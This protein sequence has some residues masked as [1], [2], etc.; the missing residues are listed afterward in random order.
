MLRPAVHRT[1]T[2]TQ[3]MAIIHFCGLFVLFFLVCCSAPRNDITIHKRERHTPT[4]IIHIAHSTQLMS[5][6]IRLCAVFSR[7]L[8]FYEHLFCARL[9]YYGG[10]L[11]LTFASPAEYKFDFFPFHLFCTIQI[12]FYTA[13]W[14]EAETFCDAAFAFISVHG[15]DWG[16]L[17]RPD[18]TCIWSSERV[19][20]GHP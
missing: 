15:R 5:V 19:N 13:K 8:T 17:E 2:G 14:W 3:T 11:H 10:K 4:R 18:E 7:R 6:C 20:H 12:L 16:H 1:H 9:R